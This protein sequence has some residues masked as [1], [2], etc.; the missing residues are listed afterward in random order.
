MASSRIGRILSYP[1]LLDLV[2]YLY[3]ELLVLLC[4]LATDKDLDGETTPFNLLEMF[5]WNWVRWGGAHCRALGNR[6]FLGRRQDVECVE[7]E[8][9]E[10]CRKLVAK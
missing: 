6:T 9:H 10:G 4:V 3:K 2:R 7:G 1:G 5:G 8:E